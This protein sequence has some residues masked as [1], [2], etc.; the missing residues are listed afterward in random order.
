V[1]GDLI[2]FSLLYRCCRSR[3]EKLMWK[4]F[5]FIFQE[6]FASQRGIKLHHDN[7]QS[8]FANADINLK[9]SIKR[10]EDI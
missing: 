8:T 1:A 10:I 4:L 6:I 2:N 5:F 7:I 3:P 9:V